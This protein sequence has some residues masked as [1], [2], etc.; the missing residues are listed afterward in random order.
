MT[1]YV[2]TTVLFL[3]GG[4][5]TLPAQRMEG[6]ASFYGDEFDGRLTSTGETFRQSGFMA[7]SKELPWGTVVEVT[8]VNNGLKTQVRINDCGPHTRG[9]LIDLSRAAA[10][11]LDFEKQGEANVRLRILLASNAG[12]T[13]SRSAWTKNL[14]A[15][16]KAIPPPPP[17]WNPAETAAL[18]STNAA[19]S[20]VEGMASFY[21]D[22]F[23]GRSTSTGEIYDRN[24]FTA[25]SKDYPY[26]TVLE[27][28]N[29]ATSRS[30]NV[31]VNDCGPFAGNRIIDL[32][33]AA[34]ARIGVLRA[35][36][37]AVRL[38]VI[39]MGQGGPTC[40]RAAWRASNRT[41][42]GQ[43]PPP[44]PTVPGAPATY[45]SGGT[46]VATPQA[47]QG[48]LVEAYAVQL[49]A[50]GSLA[51]AD[52]LAQELVEKGY[53]D[54]GSE[55]GG[56]LTKVYA[57]NFADKAAAKQLETRLRKAGYKNAA[58]KSIMVPATAAPTLASS[59]VATP[60]PAGPQFDPSDILFGVQVGAFSTKANADK[61]MVDLRAKNFTTVYSAK[62]GKM[63][64]VFSGKFYF[65]HQAEE[66][67]T[68]LRGAGYDKATVR[69]VQ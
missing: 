27:V 23:Q 36:S 46:A 5:C 40:N 38:R 1:K 33:Y 41:T 69:R 14:R 47:Y 51:N 42:T 52:K 12:P 55:F 48:D 60:E 21:A 50:F 34:A 19:T 28:T 25:A 15:Q 67:K 44:G 54:V 64:R 68:K 39:T 22:R 2:M 63:Y 65:Q 9:R 18:S 53:P 20:A 11:A 29:V 24:G 66:E 6:V 37:A 31:K 4:L 45:G 58:V 49:G 35:G 8:N 17:A 13:C 61:A 30:V 59:T 10:R 26:G 57:G 7:A 3:M 56:Q 16:G 43:A 62:V 32:S